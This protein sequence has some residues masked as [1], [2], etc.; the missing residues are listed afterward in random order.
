MAPGTAVAGRRGAAAIALAVAVPVALGSY[1][2]P[3]YAVSREPDGSI[4]V[5]IRGY[6]DPDGL[7]R[8]LRDFGVS[9][10]ID[11][12][13]PGTQCREPRATY[14]P[15]DNGLWTEDPAATS[16][17]AAAFILHPT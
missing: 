11:Y 13:P 12:L 6:K 5:L 10:V 7:E 16:A 17:E 4:K 3:A 8:K 14:A 1:F 2:S 9:A 15:V